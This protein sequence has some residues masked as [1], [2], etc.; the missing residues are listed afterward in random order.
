MELYMLSP[1]C[2]EI[3]GIGVDVVEIEE[4][5]KARFKKR[6]A[7]YFLTREEMRYI[8]KGSKEVEFLA[9]RF[10]AKEATIKAF[11][12]KLRPHDFAVLKKGA[13]P[14]IVFSSQKD[15]L[16]YTVHIS[17]SHTKRI[18]TAVAIVVECA[19]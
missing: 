1:L 16:R 17:I 9:S 12:K 19:V 18:A 15:A 7:E 13:R 3:A 11:P 4:V 10:A 6:L 5:R 2:M 14:Y 8:P